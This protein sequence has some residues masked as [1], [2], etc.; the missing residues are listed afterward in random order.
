[1]KGRVGVRLKRSPTG[2]PERLIDEIL[3][4]PRCHSGVSVLP[5]VNCASAT[6]GGSIPAGWPSS[7]TASSPPTRLPMPRHARAAGRGYPCRPRAIDEIEQA[8][9]QSNHA[10]EGFADANEDVAKHW[11]HARRLPAGRQHLP[12]PKVRSACHPR[13]LPIVPSSERHSTDDDE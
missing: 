6:M 4:R 5:A 12:S 2:T 3:R 8:Q 7:T 11:R 10:D 13:Y 1:M 9:S